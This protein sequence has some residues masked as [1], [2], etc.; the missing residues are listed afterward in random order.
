MSADDQVRRELS[1]R[2]GEPRSKA[3]HRA[4][5]AYGSSMTLNQVAG[6]GDEP[7][8]SW[9]TLRPVMGAVEK[10]SQFQHRVNPDQRGKVFA[11]P[12]RR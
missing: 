10:A 1:G 8:R 7:S 12:F 5:D 9:R 2:T 6:V 4:R 3:R 11:S